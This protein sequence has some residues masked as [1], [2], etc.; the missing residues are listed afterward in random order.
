MEKLPAPVVSGFI[1][2]DDS[3]EADAKAESSPPAAS[4]N[5]RGVSEKGRGLRELVR[6][7]TA[8]SQS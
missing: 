4:E 5:S 6:K 3:K 8:I 2:L 7:I 1:H